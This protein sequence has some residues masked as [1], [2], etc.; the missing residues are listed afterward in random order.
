MA[1]I[2]FNKAVSG[3]NV[4][5]NSGA[6]KTGGTVTNLV[7]VAIAP[8]QEMLGDSQTINLNLVGGDAGVSA[9]GIGLATEKIKLQDIGIQDPFNQMRSTM[10]QVSGT[11]V[12]TS[13]ETQKIDGTYVSAPSASG[14]EIEVTNGAGDRTTQDARGATNRSYAFTHMVGKTP[15][16]V[17]FS[18]HI[19]Q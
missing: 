2:G 9:S 16:T 4:N 19:T 15:T 10:P 17:C 18:G 6:V 11:E 8:P 12:M 5:H 14:Y 13:L 7:E 3:S 1:L